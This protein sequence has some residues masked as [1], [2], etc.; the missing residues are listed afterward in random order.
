MG[1]VIS[2]FLEQNNF[3]LNQYI[4]G[5]QLYPSSCVNFVHCDCTFHCLSHFF[6][7]YSTTEVLFFGNVSVLLEY[8]ST[9][10]SF[11]SLNIHAIEGDQDVSEQ[12]LP[13]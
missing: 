13:S 8:S 2:S 3:Y 6:I 7:V 9:P 1:T 5:P 4:R 10:I 12:F 11:V